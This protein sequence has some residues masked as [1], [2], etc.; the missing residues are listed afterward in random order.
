MSTTRAESALSLIDAIP[1]ISEANWR[2]ELVKDTR[3]AETKRAYV[4]DV[5][6]FFVIMWGVEP[7]FEMINPGESDNTAWISQYCLAGVKVSYG[8]I[9]LSSYGSNFRPYTIRRFRENSLLLR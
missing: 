3:S 8:A 4:R 9:H 6:Q 2:S 7:S 1:S 5:R